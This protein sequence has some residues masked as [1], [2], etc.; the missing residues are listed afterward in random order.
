[1]CAYQ[2]I[3]LFSESRNVSIFGVQKG[4]ELSGERNLHRAGK[5]L[6]G[7]SG[8]CEFHLESRYILRD[9]VHVINGKEER[10]PRGKPVLTYDAVATI[11]PI[12]PAY[13]SKKTS[14][15]IPHRMRTTSPPPMASKRVCY[16]EAA[17]TN[18]RPDVPSA[19]RANEDLMDLRCST[20]LDLLTM[21]KPGLFK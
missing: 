21:K 17:N 15:P 18:A 20:C 14:K 1:M 3:L 16:I 19:V 12:L 10:I 11:L 2:I 6:K 7:N 9:F 4:E 8:V 13:L 5:P